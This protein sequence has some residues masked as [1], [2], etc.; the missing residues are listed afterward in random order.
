[1]FIAYGMQ[2]RSQVTRS[3]KWVS[4]VAWVLALGP[5]FLLLSVLVH[6][7]TMRLQLGRWP[8]LF[9]D[10]PTSGALLAV[11]W[12]LMLSS[13]YWAVVGVPAWVVWALACH[14][15]VRPGTLVKQLAL[16]AAATATLWALVKFDTTGYVEWFFD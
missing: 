14:G 12:G 3:A 16:M 9:H 1:M 10:S 4:A 6:A 11:E 15:V 7:A 2:A 13:M 8:R 5:T